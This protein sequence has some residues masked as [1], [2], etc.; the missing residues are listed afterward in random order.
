MADRV[1]DGG[2]VK[3]GE[4]GVRQRLLEKPDGE[5]Q[6]ANRVA[7]KEASDIRSSQS[8]LLTTIA[9]V[10]HSLT[11][12]IAMGSSM[13]LGHDH[14]HE[15]STSG[16]TV[17]FAVTFALFLHKAPESAAYGTF[18]LHKQCPITER[19]YYSMAYAISS[20]LTAFFSY[21]IFVSKGQAATDEQSL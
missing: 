9:L 19:I 21:C 20:P 1:G 15:H 11:E 6:E 17:G 14:D 16:A 7:G 4:D 5:T 13:Y 10:V 12:G 3:L 8:A 2:I 18:L